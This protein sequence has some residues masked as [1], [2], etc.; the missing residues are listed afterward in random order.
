MFASNKYLNLLTSPK[1]F[2]IDKEKFTEDEKRAFI[3]IIK[4]AKLCQQGNADNLKTLVDEKV[5]EV[6]NNEIS[7]N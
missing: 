2:G 3:S 1:Y 5:E 4:Y 7:K 6:V